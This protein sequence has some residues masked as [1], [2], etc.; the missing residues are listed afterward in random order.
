MLHIAS[1]SDCTLLTRHQTGD[2]QAT[3]LVSTVEHLAAKGNW[4]KLF[5]SGEGGEPKWIKG[6]GKRIIWSTKMNAVV[7]RELLDL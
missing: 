6:D 4:L 5:A 1:S 7:A 2:R 3:L